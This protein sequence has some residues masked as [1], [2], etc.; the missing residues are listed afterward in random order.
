MTKLIGTTVENLVTPKAGAKHELLFN[1]PTSGA[2]VM[3][4]LRS[5]VATFCNKLERMSL[6]SLSSLVQCLEVRPGACPREELLEGAS[7]G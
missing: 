4:F 1:K 6:A 3:K 2:N 7:L 5:Y